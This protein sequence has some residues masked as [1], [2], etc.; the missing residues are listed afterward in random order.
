M[1]ETK[2]PS[3]RQITLHI[4]L[5]GERDVLLGEDS[6]NMDK[7]IMVVISSALAKIELNFT[8]GRRAELYEGG[9]LN[10]NR[11]W[12]AIHFN[13]DDDIYEEHRRRWSEEEVHPETDSDPGSDADVKNYADS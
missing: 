11:K 10:P 13:E 7:T 9:Y 8:K 5:H 12:K 4:T 1:H 6:E 3:L 2:F